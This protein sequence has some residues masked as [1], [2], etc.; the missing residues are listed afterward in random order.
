MMGPLKINVIRLFKL[1]VGCSR[2]FYARSVLPFIASAVSRYTFINGAHMAF[3]NCSCIYL[4]IQYKTMKSHY[5]EIM[6]SLSLRLRCP[7]CASVTAE[8]MVLNI[9]IHI[10]LI[11]L[12]LCSRLASSS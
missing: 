12:K 1:L 5:I 3:D 8:I 11:L 6:N 9:H 7:L 2:E 4:F 10:H